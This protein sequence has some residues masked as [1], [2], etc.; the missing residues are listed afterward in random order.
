MAAQHTPGP[1]TNDGGVVYGIESRPR[2]FGVSIDIFDANEW[3]AEIAEEAQAN[4]RL[5]AAA[6]EL[7]AA[8]RLLV[9]KVGGSWRAFEYDLRKCMGN[10]NYIIVAESLTKASAAIAKATKP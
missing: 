4:A 1:W 3:P 5:I 9:A 2:F 8:C 6:P 7:L 10:T